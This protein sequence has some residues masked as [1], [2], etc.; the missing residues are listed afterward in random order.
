MS[1]DKVQIN[2]GDVVFVTIRP[3]D[4]N[5]LVRGR[6]IDSDEEGLLIFSVLDPNLEVQQVTV[7]QTRVVKIEK[8]N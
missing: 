8:P 5:L 7:S 6:Y 3:D 4:S 1:G 2:S